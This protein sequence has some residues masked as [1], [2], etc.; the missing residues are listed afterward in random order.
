MQHVFTTIGVDPQQSTFQI[1]QIATTTPVTLAVQPNGLSSQRQPAPQFTSPIELVSQW[2]A[3][4]G[5]AQGPHFTPIVMSFTP[6]QTSLVLV[7]DTLVSRSLGATFSELTRKPTPLVFRVPVPTLAA[8]VTGSTEMIPS[9]VASSEP[10]QTVTP[11]LEALATA[12]VTAA[13]VAPLP[14]VTPTES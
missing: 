14:I 11:T 1:G 12:T 7:T 9:S 8:P 5:I 2:F 13:D 3:S 4:L 6:T 10:P